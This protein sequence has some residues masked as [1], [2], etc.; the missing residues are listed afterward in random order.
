M[1]GETT[2][3]IDWCET[4]YEAGAA[5]FYLLISIVADPYSFDPDPGFR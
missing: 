2:A 1:W 3:S 4:N 5:Y